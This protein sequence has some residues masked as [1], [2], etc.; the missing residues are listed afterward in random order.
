MYKNEKK[1][2]DKRMKTNGQFY[3]IGH[4]TN[5]KYLQ[6]FSVSVDV[7]VARHDFQMA[8]QCTIYTHYVSVNVNV[9]LCKLVSGFFFVLFISCSIYKFQPHTIKC[10][11]VYEVV[12]QSLPKNVQLESAI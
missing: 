3:C 12:M 9:Y 6:P 2:S 7:A 5:E 1:S 4:K 10:G 8:A 11:H